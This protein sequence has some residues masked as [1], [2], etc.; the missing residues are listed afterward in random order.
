M[1][2]LYEAKVFSNENGAH[3]DKH[4]IIIDEERKINSAKR[5]SIAANLGYAETVFINDIDKA[6]V[7]FFA[8]TGEISFAGTP[9]L[10][11]ARMLEHLSGKQPASL[12]SMGNTI[13]L[14]FKGNAIWVDANVSIMP[15][16]HHIQLKSASDVEKFDPAEAKKLEHTMVWAWSDEKNWNHTCPNFCA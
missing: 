14:T 7:S 12:V 16:W 10:A 8:Q 9:A 3:G 15:P 2:D 5:Q 4:G 13:P 6:D 11:V 1:I